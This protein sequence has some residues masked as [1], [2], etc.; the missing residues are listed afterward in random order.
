MVKVDLNVIHGEEKGVFHPPVFSRLWSVRNNV[1]LCTGDAINIKTKT[2]RK[3]KPK[4]GFLKE[5]N[6]KA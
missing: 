1:D 2:K 6:N 5:N 3:L 4:V